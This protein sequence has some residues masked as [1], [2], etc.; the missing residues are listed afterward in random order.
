MGAEMNRR[1]SSLALL[2]TAK[3]GIS[4]SRFCHV[5]RE[6]LVAFVYENLEYGEIVYTDDHHA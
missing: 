4:D 5:R 3:I 2:R 1:A 6:T